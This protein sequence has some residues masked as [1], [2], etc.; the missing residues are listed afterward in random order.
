VALTFDDGPTDWTEPILDLL[1]LNDASA[2]FFVIGCA[3]EGRADLIGRILSEGHEL[4][5][6][7]WSHPWLARDCDDERVRI[8]LARANEILED[9]TGARP[10]RFRAPHYDFDARIESIARSLGLAH[11]RGDVTPPDWDER[12]AAPFLATYVLQLAE[13]GAIIGLHDGAPPHAGQSSRQRTVEAV[14]TILPRLKDRGF[15]VLTATALLD[16]RGEGEGT[17]T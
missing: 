13:D 12:F 15:D 5:N 17:E 8:E 2:T 11:T 4:G 16:S 3:A 6:H 9:L 1:A 10:S 7:T 14:A